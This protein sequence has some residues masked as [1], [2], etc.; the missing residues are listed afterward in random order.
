MV[1]Y[2]DHSRYNEY[3]GTP[4]RCDTIQLAI[5]APNRCESDLQDWRESAGSI[6]LDFWISTTRVDWSTAIVDTIT[7]APSL[8]TLVSVCATK[9]F[10][11]S[12]LVVVCELCLIFD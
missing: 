5:L 4:S 10:R 2:V 6:M 11:T 7:S 1:N 12:R 8:D 3:S 9:L